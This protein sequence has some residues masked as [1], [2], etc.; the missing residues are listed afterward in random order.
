MN[1]SRTSTSFLYPLLS[2]NFVLRLLFIGLFL[3]VSL[4]NTFAIKIRNDNPTYFSSVRI[5]RWNGCSGVQAWNDRPIMTATTTPAWD[6]SGKSWVEYNI[7]TCT[8]IKLTGTNE[9]PSTNDILGVSNDGC[10]TMSAMVDINTRPT[11][12]RVDCVTGGAYVPPVPVINFAVTGE[13]IAD[14]GKITCFLSLKPYLYYCFFFSSI[15]ASITATAV[16]LTI[17]LTELSISKI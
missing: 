16:T 3:V 8:D 7:S 4:A 11:L 13:A 17:S 12:T 9:P 6:T 14:G 5:H 2:W 15:K 10:Y 1:T